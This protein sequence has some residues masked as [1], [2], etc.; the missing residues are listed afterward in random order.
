MTARADQI[1]VSVGPYRFVIC[2]PRLRSAQ[3]TLL[4]RLSPPTSIVRIWSSSLQFV[5]RTCQRVGVAWRI[6]MPL[7][8]I[9]RV[10]AGGFLT[11]SL[12][13]MTRCPLLTSG[14]NNSRAAISNPML[15]VAKSRS[16]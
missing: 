1:V 2:P 8:T 9:I 4:E 6:V 11:I 5:A 3:A 10:R 13:A 15:V 14:R 12:G 7:L 16:C